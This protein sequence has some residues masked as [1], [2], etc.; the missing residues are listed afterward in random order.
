VDVQVVDALAPMTTIVDN[1]PK[2]IFIKTLLPSN[3]SSNEHQVAKQRFVTL[4]CLLKLTQPIPVFWDN[5]EVSLCHW[6]DVSESQAISILVNNVS[7][8]FFARNL[9]K[10]RVNLWLGCLCFDLL[11]CLPEFLLF[12]LEVFEPVQSDILLD[13]REVPL[14]ANA[15]RLPTFVVFKM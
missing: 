1:Y 12:K 2:A 6:R 9:I 15:F 3:A 14:E 11:V 7:R 5:K 10:K 8:D 4:L 13:I